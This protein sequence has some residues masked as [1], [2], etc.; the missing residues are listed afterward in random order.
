MLLGWSM[1]FIR[2]TSRAGKEVVPKTVFLVLR[3][4][5]VCSPH[6]LFAG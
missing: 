2:V 3:Q 5:S 6:L 4:V 1:K